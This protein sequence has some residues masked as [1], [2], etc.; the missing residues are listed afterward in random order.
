MQSLENPWF[1]HGLFPVFVS[2][3]LC[4]TKM[5]QVPGSLLTTA[6]T[7]S[8]LTLPSHRV[9]A[10]AYLCFSGEKAL[11]LGYR[12]EGSGA[13]TQMLMGPVAVMQDPGLGNE[14][15]ASQQRRICLVLNQCRGLLRSQLPVHWTVVGKQVLQEVG[16]L[17]GSPHWNLNS[18]E[19]GFYKR[20]TPSSSVFSF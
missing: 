1:F 9:S 2:R 17:H 18:L 15:R 8:H 13:P 6:N 3:L 16:I 4:K 11:T 20:Q 12:I 19:K 7:V 10:F 5:L 14:Q